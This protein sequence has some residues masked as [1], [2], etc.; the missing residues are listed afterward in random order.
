MPGSDEQ[1]R[2]RN[3]TLA[4]LASVVPTTLALLVTL[5]HVPSAAAQ[6]YKWTDADGVVHY[7]SEKPSSGADVVAFRFP[8]YAS[9]PNCSARVDWEH[10]PLN[11]DAFPDIIREVAGVH[12]V[13]ESL[14]RAII[15]AESAY[16]P[17][18]RSPKGAQGL[19]QLMPD[20]QRDLGVLDPYDP[21]DNIEAGTRYLAGLLRRFGG[22]ITL[23]SAAYNAGPGA[24]ERHGG[25]P[26]YA[27]TREYVRRVNILHRRYRQG[28]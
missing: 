24:V 12:R 13:E 7:S 5:A 16:Q 17:D 8:C 4:A 25:V 28:S 3:G 15:H 6:I 18:A 14:I 27:E 10:V 21:V 19:M 2:T 22:D 23:A 20:T 9:D 1:G 26:P 11:R